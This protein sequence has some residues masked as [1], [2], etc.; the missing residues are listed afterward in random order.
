MILLALLAPV[1]MM[2]FLFGMS[3][4]EEFLFLRPTSTDEVSPP[5][6]EA[7]TPSP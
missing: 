6:D 7:E 5:A 3:A 4:L 2:A 1:L